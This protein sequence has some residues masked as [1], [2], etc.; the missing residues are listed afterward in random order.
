MEL[1]IMELDKQYC[2]V[3]IERYQA[4]SGKEAVRED[5]VKY[6]D[7]KSQPIKDTI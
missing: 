7:L 1:D 3:I 5:G 2:D 4:Y 6:N